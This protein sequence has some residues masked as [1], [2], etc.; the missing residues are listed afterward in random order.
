[1]TISEIMKRDRCSYKEAQRKLSEAIDVVVGN[2]Q[3]VCTWREDDDGYYAT[4]CGHMHSFFNG[5]PKQN[6]HSFCPYCGG[7]LKL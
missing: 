2:V 4:D 1:M 3:A 5:G 7:V 6:F